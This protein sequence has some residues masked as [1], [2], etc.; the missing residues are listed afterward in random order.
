[1]GGNIFG[2]INVRLNE[3]IIVDMIINNKVFGGIPIILLIGNFV[4]FALINQSSLLLR[5]AKRNIEP[6]L[7]E[8]LEYINPTDN[9]RSIQAIKIIIANQHTETPTKSIIQTP[10]GKHINA[11][12]RYDSGFRLFKRFTDVIILDE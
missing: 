5:Y 6:T 2:T 8:A 1:M 11:A 3:N 4:Q 7:K 12:L 10:K 9:T